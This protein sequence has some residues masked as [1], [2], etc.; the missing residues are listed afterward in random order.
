MFPQLPNEVDV[1]DT[2]HASALVK[3]HGRDAR[4]QLS[5]V[6]GGM[7]NDNQFTVAQRGPLVFE[8]NQCNASLPEV[9]CG[10]A[11]H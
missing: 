7:Q 6:D 4:Q 8:S 10:Q 11:T 9:V 1:Y 5:Q 2:N 3:P